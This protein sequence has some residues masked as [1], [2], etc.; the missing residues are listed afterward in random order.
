MKFLACVNIVLFAT[1]AAQSDRLNLDA[2]AGLVVE[3]HTPID[4][5]IVGG[6][7]APPNSF[8]YFTTVTTDG[9]GLCGA[10]LIHNTALQ[11]Q[12]IPLA[13]QPRLRLQQ[14]VPPAQLVRRWYPACRR[15]RDYPPRL[16]YRY[17]GE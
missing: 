2:I 13:P 9:L 3:P 11:M 1:V 7:P 14:I 6:T 15:L 4:S 12:A 16:Q 17:F 8:P 10:S 5:R